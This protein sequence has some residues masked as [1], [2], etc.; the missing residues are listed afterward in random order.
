MQRNRDAG[1]RIRF[2]GSPGRRE[3]A[4]S[5]QFYVIR[6]SWGRL[7][8][9]DVSEAEVAFGGLCITRKRAIRGFTFFPRKNT[10]EVGS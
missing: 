5:C 6:L 1:A 8:D 10:L 2:S 7:S 9:N 4:R 3:S